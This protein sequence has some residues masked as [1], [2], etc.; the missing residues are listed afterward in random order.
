MLHMD[1][2]VHGYPTLPECSPEASIQIADLFWI[3]LLALRRC[4]HLHVSTK[5]LA[6]GLPSFLA[7]VILPEVCIGARNG[8]R[9]DSAALRNPLE[10]LLAQVTGYKC[11]VGRVADGDGVNGQSFSDTVN[12][13][14]LICFHLE[15]VYGPIEQKDVH[16]DTGCR[17][18][19]C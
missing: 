5:G 3:L 11:A 8:K 1:C 12:K 10:F 16:F 14:R 15:R 13:F 19:R 2:F 4:T 6:D 9:F 17:M 7:F 18:G